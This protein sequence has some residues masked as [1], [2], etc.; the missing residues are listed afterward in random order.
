MLQSM[1]GYGH[2]SG[3]HGELAIDVEIRTVN[4]RFL[5]VSTRLSDI[6]AS[7]EPK[8]EGVVRE[9]LRR[10]TVNISIRVGN[11]LQGDA[12]Q[13]QL[14]TL[15][16]YIDQVTS[17]LRD[18]GHTIHLELGSLLQLP[19]VLS[20]PT[21]DDSE[22]LE[23]T[24]TSVLR[25]AL[26]DL[27]RMRAI[28]GKAM[29]QQLSDGVSEI[30]AFRKNILERAP[31]VIDEYRRRLENQVR[32]SL[33]ELGHA[34]SEIDVLREVLQHSDR[35]DI[36]EELVRLESHLDQFQQSMTQNESQGRRLDFLIQEL[37]RETNTI[38]SKANDAT[39][40]HNVVSI[41]T[42]IEQMR[43]LVQNIE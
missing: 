16:S 1:T 28:E 13:V 27:N 37:F 31:M 14:E 29:A 22:A 4:N 20:S 30:R 10:G 38:G 36:R 9:S 32:S 26:S 25:E 8:I 17:L 35:C 7:M 34:S 11:S 24:V 6:V 43:E 12:P 33:A 40:A 3:S 5:K 19:G 23:T 42:A 41:K 39:I 15:K 21:F 18:G 2:A